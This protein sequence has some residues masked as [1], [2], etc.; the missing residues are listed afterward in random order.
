MW[1]RDTESQRAWEKGFDAARAGKPKRCN[2][3]PDEDFR[4]YSWLNGWR[5]G[6]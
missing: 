2:P 1:D 3:Y 4:Y 6:V 5:W